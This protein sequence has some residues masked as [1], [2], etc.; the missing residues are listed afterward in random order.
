MSDDRQQMTEE[1]ER[2]LLDALEEA[3]RKGISEEALRTLIYET[4]ARVAPERISSE[5]IKSH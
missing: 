4:G 5:Q 3:A 2:Y 1:R